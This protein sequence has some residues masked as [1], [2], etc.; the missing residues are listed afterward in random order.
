MFLIQNQDLYVVI[1]FAF[2]LVSYSFFHFQYLVTCQGRKLS[3]FP[4]VVLNINGEEFILTPIQYLMIVQTKSNEFVCLSV[5]YPDDQTD[6]KGNSLWILGDY[7]L[8]R[9]YSI[10]DISNNRIGFAK[11]ISYDWASPLASSVFP[12]ITS[13]NAAN[14]IH[15]SFSYFIF[16]IMIFEFKN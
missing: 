1:S 12:D 5:F 8:Y 9:Y 13:A 14:L 10:F 15:F 7:F 2:F 6:A 3:S 11:S 4:N 16:C